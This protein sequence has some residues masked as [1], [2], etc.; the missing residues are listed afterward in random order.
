MSSSAVA[1][2]KEAVPVI[3]AIP[4]ASPVATVKKGASFMSRVSSFLS[5]LALGSG[6]GF[7]ALHKDVWD[8]T[9]QLEQSIYNLK[10]DIVSENRKL[11]QSVAKL[12][13]EVAAIK[14]GRA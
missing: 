9:V 4:K 12:E 10:T 7:Y 1:V 5:G 13:K 3:A 14:A 6:V 8:S 2:Q 11:R